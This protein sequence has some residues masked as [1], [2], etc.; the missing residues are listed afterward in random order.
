M[1]VRTGVATA[2]ASYLTAHPQYTLFAQQAARTVDVPNVA[3][4]VTMWQDFRNGYLK[5]VVFGQ[6]PTS[7]WLHEAAAAVTA[8]IKK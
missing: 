4:G 6:E 2:Y 8:D 1:P 5:S 7:Q 3:N